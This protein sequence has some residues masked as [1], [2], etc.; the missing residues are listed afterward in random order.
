MLPLRS[1][2][3]MT[4]TA[5][6]KIDFELVVAPDVHGQATGKLYA[7]DGE[8]ISPPSSMQVN[9]VFANGK[10]NISGSFGYNL[11]VNVSRV[12]FLGVGSTPSS[13]LVNEKAVGTSEYAYDPTNKVLDVDIGEPFNK[14]FS[15]EY[16]T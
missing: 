6:R 3:A 10:L 2:S 1:Q 5:L 4:T 7:D 12:R 14:S 16:Q 11:G 9:M 8:S 13:V 15:V